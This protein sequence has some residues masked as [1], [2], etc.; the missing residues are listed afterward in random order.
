MITGIESESPKN[1]PASKTLPPPMALKEKKFFLGII[2]IL[3]TGH[4]YKKAI[5]GYF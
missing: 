2:V 5:G 3:K 4:D 1:F